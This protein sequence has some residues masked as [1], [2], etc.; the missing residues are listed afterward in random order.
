MLAPFGVRPKGTLSAR[1][2]PLATELHRRG[3]TIRIIAPA[4][5]HPADAGTTIT[6]NGVTVEHG[7]LPCLPEPAAT[8]ETAVL[9]LRAAQRWQPDLL[10]LFKPKGYSGLAAQI[11]RIV[12]ADLPLVV[13]TDDWEGRGGWN[14]LAAYSWPMKTVFAWQE[15][16]LPRQAAAVTVASR[17]L[18]TQMWGFGVDPRRVWCVPNGVP[19]D[20]PHLPTRADARQ[21]LALGD[22][23]VVLLYTRFWEYD[24]RD[25]VAVLL[26]LHLHRPDAR[27]LV[28]GAGERGEE[29][30]LTRLATHAGVA[31]QL[32]QRGWADEPTIQAALAAADVALAPFADTLMNRAK[33]M[34]KLLQLLHSGVPVVASRVGQA[35]EYL[36][37]G[38]GGVLV[39]PDNGGALAQATLDLLGDP[40]RARELGCAGQR[41]VREQ[42][43]WPALATTLEVAY[44]HVLE[45]HR[46]R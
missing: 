9:L 40:D 19:V 39:P 42:F 6:V 3:H 16:T 1:M 38:R 10:H 20:P 33:G 8:I 12:R 35:I 14:D 29:H 17:T 4:Y 32:D 26:G 28:I 27:L 45:Y 7:R 36:A 30:E 13:D 23:A 15:R 34:A 21:R 37:D 46:S 5:L 41:I 22:G 44:Q 18:Q 31:A 43:A 11:A 24:L 25:V 2:L